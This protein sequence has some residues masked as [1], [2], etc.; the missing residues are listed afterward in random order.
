[1]CGICLKGFS[2]PLECYSRLSKEVVRESLGAYF[3][4][5]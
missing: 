4:L 5:G 1:M 3:Q 2:I